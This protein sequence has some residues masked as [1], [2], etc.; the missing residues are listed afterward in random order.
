MVSR[1]VRAQ[2][3]LFLGVWLVLLVT[4]RVRFFRDPGSLWHIVVGRQILSTGRLPRAD[5]FSFTCPGQP[6]IANFWLTECGLARLDRLGGLDSV[7]LATATVL[8]CLYT[9]VFGRLTR[10]GMHPLLAVLVTVLA[11]AASS[12]HF[13]PRP[14]LL[15]ILFLALVFA[16]LCDFEAGRTSLQSLLWLL[17][18]FAVWTNVHG[19]VLGGLGTLG[20]TVC[21][22]VVLAPAGRQSPVPRPRRVVTL[23]ALVVACALTVLLNP[24]GLDLPRSWFTVLGSPVVTRY[25]D[26]HAPL[27][28][29]GSSGVMVGVFGL[30]YGAALVGVYPGRPRVTWLVPLVWFALAWTRIR[31]GPLF[32][33]TAVITL[34]DMLPEIRWVRW[35][36]RRGL[37]TFR[38]RPAAALTGKAML[39]PVLLVFTA[40][41]L[42]GTGCAVPVLGQ[43][44]AR[45]K[46]EESPL[47]LLADLRQHQGER[48][49]GT[50]IFNDMQFA[51]F[52]IYYTPGYRVFIDDRCELYGDRRLLDYAAAM[53]TTPALVERWAE[54][55]GFE[56][57]I[58]RPGTALGRYL[59]ESPR[60]A[61]VRVSAGAGLY[62]RK[63]RAGLTSACGGR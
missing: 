31:H 37:K 41:V 33:T 6:W 34:A 49:G 8:A 7:L 15:S 5:C 59:Q 53:L 58:V 54:E 42:Q 45:V 18:L 32:A 55:Y 48:P 17:P 14:H 2:T 24:Y 43:G 13:H 9:W 16:R 21:G 56:L 52:L 36:G 23:A 29:S 22:W 1:F 25:I 62:R 61:P 60:W 35:L 57:A 11:L 38:L 26:E 46:A 30:V 3:V 39:L 50:P 28:R 44:W 40:L 10:A 20:L 51:G 4:G 63:E 27:L 47:E 12:Y 19:G